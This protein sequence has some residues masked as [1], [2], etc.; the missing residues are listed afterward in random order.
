[1]AVLVDLR[2][3]VFSLDHAVEHIGDEVTSGREPAGGCRAG[4]TL[5]DAVCCFELDRRSLAKS[6]GADTT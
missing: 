2:R 6:T 5:V 3:A 4:P 1:V